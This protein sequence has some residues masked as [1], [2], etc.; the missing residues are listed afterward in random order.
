MLATVTK[1]EL[2]AAS[3][4]R[5]WPIVAGAVAALLATNAITAAVVAKT[6]GSSDHVE[7]P[8]FAQPETGADPAQTP[9][10][11]DAKI[12]GS[13]P[14]HPEFLF[15]LL[16]SPRCQA[17]WARMTRKDKA[18]LGNVITI[19]IYRRADPAGPSRQEALEPDVNS[20]YTT[21][22][23]RNDPTDRLCADGSITAGPTT[24]S[25]LTLCI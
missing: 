1:E 10:V 13:D 4:S 24:I 6:A 8:V 2:R 21:L 14:S 18:A 12:A 20:G 3:I 5:T 17:G 9:C 7:A 25:A 19:S 16:F 23:V 11:D 15:E 22:I